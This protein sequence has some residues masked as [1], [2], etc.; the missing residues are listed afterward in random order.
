MPNHDGTGPCG[1]NRPGNHGHLRHSH[2]RQNNRPA[3]IRIHG[4]YRDCRCQSQL[5]RPE[6]EAIYEY[7]Q[8][9]LQTRREAL[10]RELAWVEERIREKEEVQQ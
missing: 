5:Q 4:R 10:A 2:E 9:E 3:R 8:P 7:S 1:S 6:A